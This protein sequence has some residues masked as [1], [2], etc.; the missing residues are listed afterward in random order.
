MNTANKFTMM[1][2]L[3]IPVFLIV[4][5]WGFSGS[6][7]VALAIFIIASLTDSI[8]GYIARSFNQITDFGAFMDPLADKIQVMAAL[9]WFVQEGVI[10]AWVVLI[11]AAREFAVT[12]LR[13]VAVRGGRVIA[14][15]LSGKIKTFS[16]MVCIMILFLTT[17]QTVINVCAVIIVVTTIFSGIEYFVRNRDALNWRK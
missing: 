1:R 12:G 11:V 5:Y 8:D 6:R 13:L 2:L 3:L 4:L 10:P 15:G 14:A 16:T 9:L 17:S 7:Y